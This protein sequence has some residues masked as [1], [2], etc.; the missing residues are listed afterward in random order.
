MPSRKFFLPYPDLLLLTPGVDSVMC[1][2]LPAASLVELS[3]GAELDDVRFI[4]LVATST[5]SHRWVMSVDLELDADK[6]K[7]HSETK[8]ETGREKK[9]DTQNEATENRRV[10]QQK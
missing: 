6:E 8:M 1:K 2:A 7:R 5:T 3:F 9:R 4:F 10:Q